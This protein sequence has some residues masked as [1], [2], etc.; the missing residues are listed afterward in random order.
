MS[1][2]LN[3]LIVVLLI[4]T[5]S[6]SAFW[7]MDS[8]L[9]KYKHRLLSTILFIIINSFYIGFIIENKNKNEIANLKQ[10][11]CVKYENN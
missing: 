3:G 8:W 1:V 5:Y 9:I 10:S 4:I 11:S 2:F 6:S 7:C